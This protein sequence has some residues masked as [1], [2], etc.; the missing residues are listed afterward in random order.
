MRLLAQFLLVPVA[1]MVLKRTPIGA[2]RISAS[3]ALNYKALSPFASMVQ[4][5]NFTAL[6]TLAVDSTVPTRLS[7]AMLRRSSLCITCNNVLFRTESK[8]RV[9]IRA[10][11]E[12]RHE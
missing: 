9:N 6:Q 4:V 7:I 2:P 12:W 10:Y 11:R 5:G 1:S 3:F 8:Q